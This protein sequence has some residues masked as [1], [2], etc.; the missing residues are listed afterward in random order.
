M[1][2]SLWSD[3]S[4]VIRTL[5]A[6][7]DKVDGVE[8]S[9]ID[10]REVA[11]KWC[12]PLCR[13]TIVDSYEIQHQDK[14]WKEVEVSRSHSSTDHE[15]GTQEVLGQNGGNI[16]VNQEEDERARSARRERDEACI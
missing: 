9:S 1:G 15:Q 11:I 10:S 2:W 5:P 7:P 6:A 13:G 16:E 4:E 3:T 14:I 12:L 8:F